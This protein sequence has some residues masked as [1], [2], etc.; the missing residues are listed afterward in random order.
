MDELKNKAVGHYDMTCAEVAS[1]YSYW[2][3]K[4]DGKAIQD[5]R[6]MGVW[7]ILDDCVVIAYHKKGYGYAVLSFEDDNTLEGEN[8]WRNGKMFSWTWK[9]VNP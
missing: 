1:L 5:S 7:Y 2:E 3:L 8:L 4:E 9:R 6:E